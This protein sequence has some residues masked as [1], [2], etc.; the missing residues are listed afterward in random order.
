MQP[1][2]SLGTREYFQSLLWS[3][4]WN[5]MIHVALLQIHGRTH[6]VLEYWKSM[7]SP[8]FRMGMKRISYRTS[9]SINSE[10]SIAVPSLLTKL[11]QKNEEFQVIF[12]S[13]PDRVAAVSEHDQHGLWDGVLCKRNSSTIYWS[14]GKEWSC[15]K[16]MITIASIAW[17]PFASVVEEIMWITKP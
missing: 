12:G 10:R 8:L 3:D 11:K 4:C 7:P 1:F 15:L 17:F 9:W 16:K 6:K 14:L 2:L 13:S 5:Q